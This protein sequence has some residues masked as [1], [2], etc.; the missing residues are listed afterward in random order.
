[1]FGFSVA[2][3]KDQKVV[4]VIGATHESQSN[5]S[6]AGH[7]YVYQYANG[8][9]AVVDELQNR[10]ANASRNGFQVA[11]SD[12]GLVVAFSDQ[13]T[14]TAL[15]GQVK[16]VRYPDLASIVS[17]NKTA[18]TLTY[19]N[20][21]ATDP[22]RFG[23]D[24]QLSANG[25]RLAVSTPGLTVNSQTIGAVYVYDF[26]TSG[27]VSQYSEIQYIAGPAVNDGAGESVAL[28]GDGSR[29]AIGLPY[30]NSGVGVIYIYHYDSSSFGFN[31][32]IAGSG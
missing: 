29:L 9:W 25:S 20:R 4:I 2:I 6:S 13:P 10:T 26:I 21:G 30:Q 14:N 19:V 18:Q 5:V 22:D 32:Y 17:G 11:I 12:D 16:V 7:A 8:S 1:M 31:V 15:G 3:A 24:L 28:S 27:G 23:H